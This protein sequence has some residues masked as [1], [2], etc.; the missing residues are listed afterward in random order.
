MTVLKQQVGQALS[1]QQQQ[2]AEQQ[3]ASEVARL[4]SQWAAQGAPAYNRPNPNLS[5]DILS[6][7]L[8]QLG[9]STGLKVALIGGAALVTLLAVR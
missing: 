8:G 5:P 4:Q 6:N 3:M 9:S 7:M 1:A 2:A